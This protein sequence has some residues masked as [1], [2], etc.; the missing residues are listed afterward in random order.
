MVDRWTL[1]AENARFRTERLV[2]RNGR[3]RKAHFS[4]RWFTPPELRGWLEAAGFENVRFPG[5]T[6]ETRLVVVADKPR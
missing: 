6:P 5:L 2:V 3:A 1:D 4:V